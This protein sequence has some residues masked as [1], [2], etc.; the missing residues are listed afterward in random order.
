MDKSQIFKAKKN[1]NYDKLKYYVIDIWILEKNIT[2]FK[3]I[4]FIFCIHTHSYLFRTNSF[5]GDSKVRDKKIK[6]E[7][8]NMI[9]AYDF[10]TSE[11]KQNTFA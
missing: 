7:L 8:E 9:G 3:S 10:G 4:S 2:I 5:Q 6:E 11:I 1:Q